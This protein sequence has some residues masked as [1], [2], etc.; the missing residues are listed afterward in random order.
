MMLRVGQVVIYEAPRDPRIS[1]R[2]YLTSDVTRLGRVEAWSGLVPLEP[3]KG[4][5]PRE[6]LL[7]AL[8]QL[9]KR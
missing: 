6:W 3:P 2:V 8:E 5:P 4:L 7:A 1:L 9:P